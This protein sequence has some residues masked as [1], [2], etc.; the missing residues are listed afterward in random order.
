LVLHL[1]CRRGAEPGDTQDTGAAVA[2][3]PSH[4][5]ITFGPLLSSEGDL[6][7][8]VTELGVGYMRKPDPLLKL[9]DVEDELVVPL[10]ASELGLLV[11][12]RETREILD[13]Q[14]SI[15]EFPRALVVLQAALLEP[16]QQEATHQG[17][18][19][20][21]GLDA[22]PLGMGAQITATYL[23]GQP[24]F[25]EILHRVQVLAAVPSGLIE[26]VIGNEA[27]EDTGHALNGAPARP[28]C[29]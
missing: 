3:G 10:Q 13:S 26:A 28:H 27:S 4:F 16:H 15:Q 12:W 7:L 23:P 11:T 17:D 5:G 1:G 8:E 6:A 29:L 20:L 24:D 14:A 25:Q 9:E 22:V 2:S 21:G 19:M 18:D